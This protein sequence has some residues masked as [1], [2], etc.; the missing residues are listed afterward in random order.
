MLLTDSILANDNAAGTAIV[1]VSA[2]DAYVKSSGCGDWAKT[3]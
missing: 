1:K 2:S 3:G